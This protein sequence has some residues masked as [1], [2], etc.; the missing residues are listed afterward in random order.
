MS[1]PSL[2]VEDGGRLNGRSTMPP[3]PQTGYHP[4]PR[5]EEPEEN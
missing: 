3:R 1:T 2:E 4:V 5:G